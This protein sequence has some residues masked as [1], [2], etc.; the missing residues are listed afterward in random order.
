[1][2]VTKKPPPFDKT[3]NE[4]VSNPVDVH[5][6]K[7][8]SNDS[9]KQ[10]QNFLSDIK[11]QFGPLFSHKLGCSTKMKAI[12]QLKERYTR[13]FWPKRPVPQA[14][15]Q[16]VGKELDRLENIGVIS[17]TSGSSWA[18]H[19]AVVKKPNG[20]V[21]LCADYSTGLNDALKSHHHPIPLTEDL[22]SKLNRGCIFSKI[23]L[24]EAYL[25]MPVDGD[26]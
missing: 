12:L 9:T 8:H 10:I 26:F 13:V 15:Q 11:V 2:D 19:I 1:M 18:A 24:S 17:K 23:D 7:V 3:L 6:Q 20:C 5:I 25:L 14:A 22:L 4:V 16:L 21:W